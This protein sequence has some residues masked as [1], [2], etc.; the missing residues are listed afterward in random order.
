MMVCEFSF[1]EV[2]EE[3]CYEVEGSLSYNKIKFY[4]KYDKVEEYVFFLGISKSKESYY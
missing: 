4:L 3:D 1:R 2:E